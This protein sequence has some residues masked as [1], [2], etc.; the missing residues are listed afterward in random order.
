MTEAHGVYTVHDLNGKYDHNNGF[1][2][3]FL[4]LMARF[5]NSLLASLAA[6]SGRTSKSLFSMS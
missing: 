2:S 3:A 6:A 1:G 5:A 4:F